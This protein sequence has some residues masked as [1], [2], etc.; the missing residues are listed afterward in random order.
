MTRLQP[1]CSDK[2]ILECLGLMRTRNQYHEL[3]KE[4]QG[5]QELDQHRQGGVGYTMQKYSQVKER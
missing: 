2:A 5:R 3:M 4:L 1:S